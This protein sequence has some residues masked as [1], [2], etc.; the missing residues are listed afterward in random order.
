MFR[1]N[2]LLT[3]T[4]HPT[5]DV[6][7]L[8]FTPGR[9]QWRLRAFIITQN[10]TTGWLA[11][12]ACHALM[13]RYNRELL[14]CDWSL[15]K[16]ERDGIGPK[17]RLWEVYVPHAVDRLIQVMQRVAGW[18]YETLLEQKQCLIS[19]FLP[20]AKE[21]Y[22][23]WAPAALAEPAPPQP[24]KQDTVWEQ[25]AFDRCNDNDEWLRRC[26]QLCLAAG[27]R[28]QNPAWFRI[29]RGKILWP[30]SR[31][32]MASYKGSAVWPMLFIRFDAI[33]AE[34]LQQVRKKLPAP[35]EPAPKSQQTRMRRPAAADPR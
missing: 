2:P 28:Q 6:L 22:S 20:R 11:E 30:S 31:N 35:A 14:F 13:F 26:H 12:Q 23:A 7:Q 1:P 24:P 10:D 15:W 17:S 27:G 25:Y 19:W 21:F 9:H 33:R 18:N 3:A 34:L 16:R 4:G 5:A 32:M 29:C 8:A